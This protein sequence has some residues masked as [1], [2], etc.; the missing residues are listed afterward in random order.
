MP[1]CPVNGFKT[2]EQAREWK[3]QFVDWYNKEH[4]HSGINYVALEQ[5]TTDR[6]LMFWRI[7]KL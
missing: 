4:R 2:F 6:Q 3:Q 1:G 5:R 7:T